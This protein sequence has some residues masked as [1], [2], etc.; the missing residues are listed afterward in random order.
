MAVVF[1]LAG[2]SERRSDGIRQL[3]AGS[4][5]GADPGPQVFTD[6][7]PRHTVYLD[8]SWQPGVR[9]C[10]ATRGRRSGSL[11]PMQ[12]SLLPVE[13]PPQQPQDPPPETLRILAL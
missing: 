10:C 6:E 8:G 2:E 5:R 13:R 12:M 1:V 7:Q 11:L 3:W 4:L 9:V